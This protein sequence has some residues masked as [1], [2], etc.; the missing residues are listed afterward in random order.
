MPKLT[1]TLVLGAMLA[2]LGSAT[3]AVAQEPT[4]DQAVQQ[5][6]AGER[7]SQDQPVSRDEAVQRFRA[8][9]RASQSQPVAQADGSS[10]AQQ[11]HW[12]YESTRAQ[13]TTVPARPDEPGTPVGLLAALFAAAVLAL[14]LDALSVRHK[15]RK[16]AARAAI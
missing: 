15:T 8:G 2:V 6:R 11:R 12:Y 16:A 7:A 10:L 5:F 4:T 9:E 14:S 3:A 1:R 13:P